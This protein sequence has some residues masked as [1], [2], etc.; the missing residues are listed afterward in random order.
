MTNQTIVG[1]TTDDIANKVILRVEFYDYL[2]NPITPSENAILNNTRSTNFEVTD[3]P[4][5]HPFGYRTGGNIHSNW[6]IENNSMYV[7]GIAE[8][9]PRQITS[10]DYFSFVTLTTSEKSYTKFKYVQ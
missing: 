9:T 4:S 3:T 1:Q 10:A 8:T 2:N 7:V 6:V 5:D